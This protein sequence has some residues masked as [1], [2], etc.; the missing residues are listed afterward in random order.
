MHRLDVEASEVVQARAVAH[1]DAH[2][3][4]AL[5]EQARDVRA[6][7]AGPAGDQGHG[8]R[9]RTL[10]SAHGRR[11]R[12]HRHHALPAAGARSPRPASTRS[13]CTSTEGGRAEREAD[14]PTSTAFYDRLRTAAELPT[15]SQPSI[16][17]FLAVYDPLLEAGRDIVSIHISGGISGT[18]DAAR[19]AAADAVARQPGAARR[20]HRLRHGLRRPGRD[21]RWAPPPSRARARDVD[22]VAAPRPGDRRAQPHLVL[23]STPSSSCAAAGASAAPRPG[24]AAR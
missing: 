17:D 13:A 6:D 14:L 11:R 1:R 24:S 18:V 19:Q 7:Q 5:D 10:G 21:R 3:V 23:P 20:G 15:T 8:H 4:A 22:A 9:P 16:G 12:R 2:V